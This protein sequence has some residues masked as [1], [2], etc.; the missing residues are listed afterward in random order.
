M[1]LHHSTS[2]IERVAR[3]PTGKGIGHGLR[4]IGLGTSTLKGGNSP[5]KFSKALRY[6][7]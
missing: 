6:G 3:F 7:S 2:S 4:T 1:S 5:H